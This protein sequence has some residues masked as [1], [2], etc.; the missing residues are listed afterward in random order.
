MFLQ[1]PVKGKGMLFTSPK[2][3]E[4]VPSV[5]GFPGFPPV[6]PPVSVLGF[7]CGAYNSLI[8]A[9]KKLFGGFWGRNRRHIGGS[10]TVRVT[11][12]FSLAERHRPPIF[13]GLRFDGREIRMAGIQEYRNAAC[14]DFDAPLLED[15][16]KELFR[17][18]RKVADRVDAYLKDDD[19]RRKGKPGDRRNVS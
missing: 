1:L 11:R 5:P 19:S 8:M 13:T 16:E 6:S 7:P 3:A 10:I 12:N 17:I 9:D 4:N 14:T 2:V 15:E 18:F